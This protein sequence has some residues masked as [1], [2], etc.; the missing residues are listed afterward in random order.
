VRSTPQVLSKNS[1][2]L[3]Q[4]SAIATICVVYSIVLW[5]LQDTVFQLHHRWTQWDG[6]YSHGYLLVFVCVFY[7]FSSLKPK[8]NPSVIYWPYAFLAIIP[9]LI[10]SFGYSTQIGALQQVTLPAMLACLIL[11]LVGWRGSVALIF[12]FALLYLSIPVWEVFLPVLRGMTSFVSTQGVRVLGVPAFIDGFSFS[13][14]YGTVVIAGSCAGLSYFLMGLVLASI[15][16]LYRNYSLKSTLF[17]IVLMAGLAIV[18]NW[19][20]VYSLILIAYYSRMQSSLVYD[21]GNFGWWIFA[22]I[23]ILFLWLIRNLPES[24]PR[25]ADVGTDVSLSNAIRLVMV[26]CLTG[27]ISAALPLWLSRSQVDTDNYSSSI[28]LGSYRAVSVHV[29]TDRFKPHY[30]GYDIEQ[31]WQVALGGQAITVGRLIYTDQKQ[32]KELI[33]NSNRM[34]YKP[35]LDSEL[36]LLPSGKALK[37]EVISGKSSRLILHTNLI[38]REVELSTFKGKFYQFFESIAGRPVSALW[39]ATF[40]CQSA[41]CSKEIAK[42]KDDAALVDQWLS[43]AALYE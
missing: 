37:L 30:S 14:P 26:V 9:S 32:G 11:P 18:G 38:G 42:I 16:S 28:D 35:V 12:P 8:L 1:S 25:S 7:L 13:L 20:R 21:H 6:A 3:F 22:A 29:A 31:Y 17:S 36:Y 27:A 10:W 15:N 39:Y 33:T 41:D 19:I 34:H 24:S 2:S 40:V 43:A 23:F 5:V 4:L